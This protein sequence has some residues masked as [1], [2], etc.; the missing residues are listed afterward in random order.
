MGELDAV[1]ATDP[2]GVNLDALDEQLRKMGV[3][4][5]M[6]RGRPP[7]SLQTP[8]QQ[9]PSQGPQLAASGAQPTRPPVRLTGTPNTEANITAG[10]KPGTIAYNAAVGA[11]SQPN[12]PKPVSLAM[13][14]APD[15][16]TTGG[17]GTPAALNA[18]AAKPSAA[19]LLRNLQGPKREDFQEN[20]LPLWRKALGLT[21]AGLSGQNAGPLAEQ[22]LHGRE[23]QAE[24]KF[25]Q[26][27]EDFNQQ[28]QD[29]VT[30]AGLDEKEAQTRNI[31]SEIA[32]RQKPKAEKPEDQKIGEYT[33][34]DGHPTFVF[35]KPTGELYESGVPGTVKEK[36]PPVP[37]DKKEDIQDYLKSHGLEDTPANREKARDKIAARSPNAQVVVAD[38]RGRAYGR[39][40]P[41]QVLDTWNGNRPITV[42]AGDAED[43]P[44]RYVNA[45]GGTSALSKGS[46]FEDI[47]SAVGSMRS[48]IEKL[49]RP[50]TP[51]QIG[52]LTLALRSSNDPTVFRNEV[53]TML[54][55]QKLTPAQQDLV[56]W[57]SQLHERAM[58][59]RSIAGMGQ[60]SD[61][62]RTAII[63][64]LPGMKSGSKEMMNKQL[65][66][67]ENQVKLLEKGIPQVKPQGA[68]AGKTGT[69][70]AGAL[71]PGWQ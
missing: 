35:R 19:Q 4:P 8:Q 24:K 70:G 53:E 42:S 66:A 58:S 20:K 11:T 38:A 27:K 36:E 56:V 44:E 28:R 51:E 48:A 2:Q 32:A 13:P 61:Q 39:N 68:G 22:V 45:T 31:E 69:P 5:A 21:L 18:P 6:F 62:L 26:A 14:E 46:Q 59:L 15:I 71:P 65:A 47:H 3:D 41:V 63:N 1:Q 57:I 52:K 60:G 30:G 10:Y 25:E 9:G 29:I 64:T 67:F 49:D 17:T 55:T 23:Q 54:G 16:S 7:V 33:N 12:L 40:R 37:N 43:N 50:F 34:A